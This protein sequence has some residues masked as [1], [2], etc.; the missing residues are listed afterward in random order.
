MSH[1]FS[2]VQ[3]I[4]HPQ[5]LALLT[6]LSRH[7]EAYRDHALVWQLF[8]GEGM[9]RDFLFRREVDGSGKDFYYVVSQRPPQ[10][11]ANLLALQS[12]AYT[13]RLEVGEWLRFDLRANP[14]VARRSEATGKSQRHDV[15]MDAKRQAA[16][17]PEQEQIDR[18]QQAGLSW[19]EQRAASWGLVIRRE[20]VL[21]NAYV[22][23]KLH[24]KGR[25]IAFSSLDYQG[26]AQVTDPDLLA[27]SLTTGVGH[28]R[29]FGCGLLLVRRAG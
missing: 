1:Y 12:K 15:L 14:T 23:H 9:P 7:G 13:P 27:A 20:S 19:I 3:L 21:T 8:P 22:Q 24:H 25:H 6:A 28:A 16:D 11:R 26:V 29:A 5:D 17:L 10:A 4:E 2:R 18:I